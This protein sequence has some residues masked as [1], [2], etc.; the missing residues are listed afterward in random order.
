MRWIPPA[1]L[2]FFL[3]TGCSTPV[4]SAFFATETPTPTSTATATA[5][6]TPAPTSTETLT[7][8]STST[9]LP[10]ATPTPMLTVKGPGAI[11]CPILLYHHIQVPDVPNEYFVAPDDFRAQ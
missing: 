4:V 5:T 1:L 6:F 9:S 11:I 8:T 3:L 10:S 7:P 2:A